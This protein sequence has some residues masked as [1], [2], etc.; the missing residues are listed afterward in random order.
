MKKIISFLFLS[1]FAVASQS[2]WAGTYKECIEIANEVNQGVP[3]QIDRIT[4]LMTA[5][6]KEDGRKVIFT[7]NYLIDSE[8]P[9]TQKDI[10]SLKPG[11]INVLCTNPDI[12]PLINAFDIEMSYSDQTRKFI[13]YN[14]ISKK[15]CRSVR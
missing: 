15:D 1:G 8:T 7:Y 6:C 3:Q 14:R 11:Q 2:S 5:I 12:K 13:G 4:T 9:M 10:S